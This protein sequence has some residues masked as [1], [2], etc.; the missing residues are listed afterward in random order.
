MIN[1][2]ENEPE[3]LANQLG[4]DVT[5]HRDFYHLQD[6]TIELAKVSRLLIAAEEGK[7]GSF[8]GKTLEEIGIN[9]ISILQCNQVYWLF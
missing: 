3:Y 8:H 4:H 5:V 6:S 1:L 2:K 7:I 9:D